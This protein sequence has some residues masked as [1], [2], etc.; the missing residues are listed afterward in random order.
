MVFLGTSCHVTGDDIMLENVECRLKIKAGENNKNKDFSID[1]VVCAGS[2][3]LTPV[4]IIKRLWTHG[5]KQG[6]GP[7]L[8][9]LDRKTAGERKSKQGESHKQ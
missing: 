4:T 9:F 7:F 5:T 3:A 2:C 8:V 1:R 6:R